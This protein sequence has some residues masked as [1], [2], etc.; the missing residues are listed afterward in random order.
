MISK[1]KRKILKICGIVISGAFMALLPWLMLN[2]T[3]FIFAIQDILHLSTIAIDKGKRLPSGDIA[4]FFSAQHSIYGGSYSSYGIIVLM[5]F[6]VCVHSLFNIFGNRIAPLQRGYFLVVAAA[7]TAGIATYLFNGLVVSPNMAL[8]YSCPILIATL[9]FAWLAAAVAKP[10]ALPPNLPRMQMV[11]ALSMPLLAA[12]LFGGN[13]V[14]RIGQI[15]S[16]HLNFS[17]PVN[18]NYNEYCR[19]L[20]STDAEQAIREIQ[21]K[22]QPGQKM[23]AWISVPSQLDFSRNEIYSIRAQGLLNPWVGMPLNGKASDMVQ[24]L[25]AQ[26]IRYIM[27]QDEGFGLFEGLY[28]SWLSSPY[29]GYRE[30]GEIALYFRW[31]L[32]KIMRGGNFLYNSD[33]IMLYDLQQ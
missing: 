9:P 17:F 5:L 26:G 32:T 31:M 13:F 29:G 25:R 2:I 30:V 27:L 33:G 8:R 15:Y 24:F 19:T 22:T 21:Y 14:E 12:I 20:T 1:D 16:Q 23:L 6:A 4:V 3:S 7:C 18:E 11:L 10:G 28:R